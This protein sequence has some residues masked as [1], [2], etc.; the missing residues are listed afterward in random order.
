[1]CRRPW[2]C[3]DATPA[4]VTSRENRCC[5]RSAC[6]PTPSSRVKTSPLSVQ[7]GPQASRSCACCVRHVFRKRIVT[8]SMPIRRRPATVFVADAVDHFVAYSHPAGHHRDGVAVEVDGVPTQA[9]QLAA[10]HPRQRRQPPQGEHPVAFG[11]VEE[12]TELV[13]SPTRELLTLRSL[14]PFDVFGRVGRDQPRPHRPRQRRP[15]HRVGR[16]QAG[17]R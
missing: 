7:P 11:L 6:S 10:T 13:S 3:R 15:Q 14:G 9:K 8:G 2:K 5:S 4:P 1:M 16:P 17:L 12:G